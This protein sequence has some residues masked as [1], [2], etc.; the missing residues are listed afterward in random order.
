MSE[1]KYCPTCGRRVEPAPGLP[2]LRV[3][4]GSQI[5]D[6]WRD[7][8]AHLEAENQKDRA[9]LVRRYAQAMEDMYLGWGPE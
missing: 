8:A 4:T 2:E 7:Y 3:M 5:A 6:Y 1:R 9:D